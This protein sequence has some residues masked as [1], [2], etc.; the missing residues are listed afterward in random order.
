MTLFTVS[1]PVV[2]IWNPASTVWPGLEYPHG[3][4]L[5]LMVNV[6]Q[7]QSM[8]QLEG[9]KA[10]LTHFLQS[11]PQ[12][13]KPS[14]STPL[15]NTISTPKCWLLFPPCP[16]F[17]E[18]IVNTVNANMILKDKKQLWIEVKYWLLS[19][20]RAV[21]YGVMVHRHFKRMVSLGL[22][23]DWFWWFYICCAEREKTVYGFENH[24]ICTDMF[25]FV[26]EIL[27]NWS[28]LPPCSADIL[29]PVGSL[30]LLKG[31]SLHKHTVSSISSRDDDSR[32]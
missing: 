25:G 19:V 12:P 10:T 3:H 23:H 13:Q 16:L 28:F 21:G 26:L 9:P 1:L 27:V 6:L 29:L 32:V 11:K 7:L 31:Q 5:T 4:R 14:A 8:L 15:Q 24:R 18:C 22:A 30:G 2:F 20:W 17:V